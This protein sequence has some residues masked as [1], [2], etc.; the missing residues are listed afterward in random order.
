MSV[1]FVFLATLVIVISLLVVV[2]LLMLAVDYLS[3]ILE[4]LK[5]LNSKK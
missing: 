2:F 1:G 4:Q 5:E 3:K